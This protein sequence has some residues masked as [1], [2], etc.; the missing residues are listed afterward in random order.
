M[1]KEGLLI[2]IKF[3]YSSIKSVGINRVIY[4]IYRKLISYLKSF[5]FKKCNS[6]LLQSGDQIAGGKFINIGTLTAGKYCRIEA[7][8][9]LDKQPQI[10]IGEGVSFGHF[11]HIACIQTIDIGDNVMFGSNVYVTDHD[12]GDYSE[13]SHEAS[14]PKSIPSSR[15]VKSTPVIIG[16]NVFIGE[17]VTILKGVNIGDGVV[18]GSGSVVTKSIGANSLAVGVPALIIKRYSEKENKWLKSND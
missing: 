7:L 15:I 18:I 4:L 5:Q 3:L 12:H 10:N 8:K 11:V 9:Y 17:Y 13:N 2:K 14:S 6:L 16:N 1:Y